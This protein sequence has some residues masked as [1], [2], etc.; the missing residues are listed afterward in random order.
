LVELPGDK[1][2]VGGDPGR[3]WVKPGKRSSSR[4]KKEE[5]KRKIGLGQSDC[6]A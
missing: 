1:D 2:A 6:S 4:K 3:R 5:L